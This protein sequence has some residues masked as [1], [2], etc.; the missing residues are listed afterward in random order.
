M[1]AHLSRLLYPSKNNQI[2][3]SQL[4][5]NPTSSTCS[6]EKTGGD[7]SIT[8]EVTIVDAEPAV[9]RKS[10]LRKE[11]SDNG[12]G[13]FE[14]ESSS[15]SSSSSSSKNSQ[16]QRR[17]IL[18]PG[19][20]PYELNEVHEPS[21]L[22]SSKETES[23]VDEDVKDD[24]SDKND[25]KSLSSPRTTVRSIPTFKPKPKLTVAEYRYRK[26][27]QRKYHPRRKIAIQIDD[28]I[29]EEDEDALAAEN[30]EVVSSEPLMPVKSILKR[31]SPPQSDQEDPNDSP[32][33]PPQR[34]GVR[35]DENRSSTIRYPVADYEDSSEFKTV[36]VATSDE[37]SE[38]EWYGYDKVIVSHNL[39]EEILN[40]I[41]GK[42]T[43]D[44]TATA[45]AAADNSNEV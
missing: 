20:N 9:A 34:K 1:T 28:V 15:D 27:Q 23:S 19:L 42:S 44:A 7:S 12:F 6:C 45:E 31:A 35:F 5:S 10:N 17:S 22:P 2:G 24:K 32:S 43:Y 4:E 14:D 36:S 40:E 25:E 33:T 3:S 38:D 11:N 26:F 18:D 41:Y 8:R 21:L 37:S 29:L 16:K 30:L 39:A 13:P